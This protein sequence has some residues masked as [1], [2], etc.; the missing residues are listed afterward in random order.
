MTSRLMAFR[1]AQAAALLAAL[2]PLAAFSLTACDDVSEFSTQKGESYCGAITLGRSFR[3]GLGPRVQMRLSLDASRI[4]AQRSPGRVWAWEPA[5]EVQAARTLL[6]AATL[7]PFAPIAHDALGDLELGEGRER[8]AIYAVRPAGDGEG[9]LAFLSLRTDGRVEVRLLRAG[10][11]S[12]SAPA[13]RTPL[14]GVFLLE[15]RK[16]DCG[17]GTP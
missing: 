7:D 16:G 4:D 2:A 15:R 6:E 11:Q 12:E 3:E 1:G 9:M 10:L 8:N 17:F 5:S 13:D 14:F